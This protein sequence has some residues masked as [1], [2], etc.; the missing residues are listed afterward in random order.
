MRSS[1]N[2]FT[3]GF[4]PNRRFFGENTTQQFS[5]FSKTTQNSGFQRSSFQTNGFLRPWRETSLFSQ[6]PNS[7]FQNRFFA[8]KTIKITSFG[9]DSITEGTVQKWLKNAGDFVTTDEL[10]AQIETDKV[11]VDIRAPEP[12]QITE[13]IAKASD[14][15]TVGG[16]LYRLDTDAKGSS[17]S[18]A[19]A[20][21]SPTPEKPVEKAKPVEQPK[22]E[23]PTEKAKPAESPKPAEASKAAPPS[24]STVES[25]ASQTGQR[26]RIERR[27]QMSRMRARIAERLKDSQ[28]T[29]AML[30]TF[31]ECDM[32]NLMGMRELYKD[33]FNEKHGIKL[34][35]MSAFVKASAIALQEQPNVNAVIDDKDKSIIYRDYVDISVAV[36]T[37]TGLVVPVVRDCDLLSFAGI[38]KAIAHYGKKARDGQ[39]ALEDMAGGTFTISNGGVYGSMMG[40]PIINPPQSAI[41]GMHAVTK[42]AVVVN[43]TIVIR[44]M[45]YLALTYD[46][47]V[48]D[49]KDA[50]T[51]LKRIKELIEDPRRML[52]S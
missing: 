19:K 17:K 42:R 36:A 21:P 26:S 51:F 33:E 38:E 3:S 27:V 32:S 49:G 12:G 8:V 31:N 29:M 28:N 23:K 34:G 13:V 22:V 11:V 50:V 25:P 18:E 30:T 5:S 43:D 41:L 20:A 16:E 45:M 14:T 37:P 4:M 2:G 47:R 6:F 15:V 46:H 35:F 39:I 9:A 52:L 40:T 1:R 24:K 7:F 48:I 10:V 44:P